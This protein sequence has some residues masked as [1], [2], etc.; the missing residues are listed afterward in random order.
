MVDGEQARVPAG[1]SISFL[2]AASNELPFFNGVG[3]I[4]NQEHLIHGGFQHYGP[5][6]GGELIDNRIIGS[7]TSPQRAWYAQVDPEDGT[8]FYAGEHFLDGAKLCQTPDDPG[9]QA[10]NHDCAGIFGTDWPD[11]DLVWVACQAGPGGG[12]EETLGASAYD[13]YKQFTDNA[14]DLLNSMP[15]DE[16]AGW[17]DAV[18][19]DRPDLLAQ[20]QA[21]SAVRRWSLLREA[22]AFIAGHTPEEFYAMVESSGAD[23]RPGDIGTDQD[24]YLSEADLFQVYC[25]GK[26]ARDGEEAF[27][28]W[29]RAQADPA[30]A[31]ALQVPEIAEAVTR[32]EAGAHP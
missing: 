28:T 12:V 11:T 20:L 9:C 27:T 25:V 22:R 23:Q 24:A 18:A 26:M 13:E 5:H 1:W 31:V 19:R 29:I 8:C 7:L 2:V 6:G 14:Y 4:A 21:K 15:P 16:F 10:G 17:Y 32:V 3:Y 30:P